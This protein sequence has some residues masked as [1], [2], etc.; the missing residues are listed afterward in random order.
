MK[1]EDY[2]KHHA[3]SCSGV[4]ELLR[5][6]AHYQAYLN[7]EQ[8]ETPAMFL[9]TAAHCAILEPDRFK[10]EY[11]LGIDADKRTKEW[12]VFV[13]EN[14]DKI[15][16]SKAEWHQ[17]DSIAGAVL[18]HPTAG[19]LFTKGIAEESYFSELEGVTVKCRPDYIFPHLGICV[20]LK[21]TI[22]ASEKEFKK[23]CANFK[24]H[25]QH[26]FYRDVLASIGIIIEN[27]IFVAVEKSPPY[28]VGVYELDEDAFSLGREQYQKA[29]EIYKQA[30]EKEAWEGYT[31]DI[32]QLSLPAWV[33]S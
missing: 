25:I 21:T 28:G 29:L 20:D 22:D 5:S 32:I 9:G 13:A 1:S 6:P 26:A 23:S 12:K 19:K 27:F 14:T 10:E 7:R 4:K 15:I 17:V 8:K 33:Q 30:K 16:L 3:L 31:S 11:I 24:Y 2:H 18:T